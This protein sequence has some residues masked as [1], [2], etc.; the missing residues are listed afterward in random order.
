MNPENFIFSNQPRYRVSRHFIF[1]FLWFAFMILTVH[2]PG[3]RI[4]NWHFEENPAY[5]NEVEKRGGVFTMYMVMI[6][7]QSWILLCQIAFTYAIVYYILPRYY[8]NREKWLA[9]TG[10]LVLLFLAYLG[11]SYFAHSLTALHN[12]RQRKEAGLSIISA[13]SIQRLRTVLFSTTFNLSTVIGIT[14]TIKLAKRWWVKQKETALVLR[15][16]A[17]AELQLLKSQV[18]PHFLFNSLNN[19]YAFALEGSSKAP[20]MIQK[21]SGL[22][23]YML[24]DCKQSL[25][26]LQKELALLND[27][28][29]LEKIRYGDR[30]KIDVQLPPIPSSP[31]ID[32]AN[33]MIAP[34]LLIPFVENS[35][36]H[37]TSKMLVQPFVM[38]TISVVDEILY[39]KL[40]NSKPSTLEETHPNASG[41]LGLRNAK[42]RLNL[43]YPG[44]HELQLIDEEGTFT[45]WLQIA[46]S[47]KMPGISRDQLKKE[48]VLYELG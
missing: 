14:V 20:E 28:I 23:H 22:L 45:I 29:S 34:L 19:I 37:G 32:A 31:T 36:K 26:P 4:L 17:S 43:M 33:R 30:L 48:K 47:V 16:K 3:N 10:I 39:F 27:Y 1:W 21:L 24:H 46:L 8:A 11:L 6:W 42:K 2:I 18:H 12:L 15:E 44:R 40:I 5:L 35:F 13:D 7:R 9:T 25:V 41:G 38:L